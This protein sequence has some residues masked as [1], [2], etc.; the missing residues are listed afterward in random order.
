MAH[1]TSSDSDNEIATT[2]TKIFEHEKSI[3]EILGGGKGTI[4]FNFI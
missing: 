4:N 3:H 2:R 1:N